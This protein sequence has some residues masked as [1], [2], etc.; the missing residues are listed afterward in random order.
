MSPIH[1]HSLPI[2]LNVRNVR[3][4]TLTE[5]ISSSTLG[6]EAASSVRSPAWITAHPHRGSCSLIS[7]CFNPIMHKR[8]NED[9]H[10]EKEVGAIV[11]YRV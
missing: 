9:P 11:S 1:S 5:N 7:F 3:S 2:L 6:Y 4:K 8:T 10:E